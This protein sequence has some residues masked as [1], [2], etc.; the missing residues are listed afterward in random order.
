MAEIGLINRNME[1]QVN[2]NTMRQL[3]GYSKEVDWAVGGAALGFT[4][5]L[6]QFLSG[7]VLQFLDKKRQGGPR[8]GKLWERKRRINRK[9]SVEKHTKEPLKYEY[10]YEKDKVETDDVYDYEDYVLNQQ[11][12]TQTV[13]PEQF[14]GLKFSKTRKHFL[15]G[16][17]TIE[18]KIM[19]Y[20][21]QNIRMQKNMFHPSMNAYVGISS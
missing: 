15:K 9:K 1:P 6:L 17:Q 7:K 14:L 8:R 4:A 18:D 2:Q 13:L 12:E 10:E 20:S 3:L 11:L 16:Q 19:D 21:S 5:G